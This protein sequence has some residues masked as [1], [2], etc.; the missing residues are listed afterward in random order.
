[1]GAILMSDEKLKIAI[2]G[3]GGMGALFGVILQEGG[4]EIAAIASSIS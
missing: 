3:A 4:H 1:M 2:A